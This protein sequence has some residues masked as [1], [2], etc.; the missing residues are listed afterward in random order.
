[1]NYPNPFTTYTEFWFEHN[2]P[3][4][5]LQVQI[6][7][8]TIS[9]K[10]IKTINTNVFTA[11]FRPD[12]KQTPDLQWNGTDDYGL[13]KSI[14]NSLRR[15]LLSEI[16]CIAFRTEEGGK[17]DIVMEVNNTS[18]HN[19]FLLHRLS[20]IPLYLDPETYENQY[21]FYYQLLYFLIMNQI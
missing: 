5:N 2:R 10:L 13:D 17:K 14:V 20:M 1:M 9:G 16:P 6:Q 3:N 18:L 19:E 7:I 11:G 8:F 4:E 21:L 12:P 15:T